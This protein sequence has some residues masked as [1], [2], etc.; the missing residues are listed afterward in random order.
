MSLCDVGF[1]L[2][3]CSWEP[4]NMISGS[5]VGARRDTMLQS[6]LVSYKKLNA[7]AFAGV[8]VQMQHNRQGEE[9]WTVAMT[10]KM[11]Q[12]INGSPTEQATAQER[13]ASKK[14]CELRKNREVVAFLIPAQACSVCWG[15]QLECWVCKGPWSQSVV[16]CVYVNILKARADSRFYSSATGS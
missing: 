8:L 10:V 5:T 9:I 3:V 11:G 4:L 6:I 2:S 7:P 13:D 15:F 14:V 12:A 16:V 1:G